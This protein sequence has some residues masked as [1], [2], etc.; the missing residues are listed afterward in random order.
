MNSIKKATFIA[1]YAYHVGY[2]T[3]FIIDYAKVKYLETKKL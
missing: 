2:N 3:G 1:I